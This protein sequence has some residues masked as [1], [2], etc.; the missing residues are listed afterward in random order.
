MDLLAIPNGLLHLCFKLSGYEHTGGI[1]PIMSVDVLP[2]WL[3]IIDHNLK[4][5]AG[6]KHLLCELGLLYINELTDIVVAAP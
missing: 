4:T 3:D 2:H 5:I 1:L 6:A